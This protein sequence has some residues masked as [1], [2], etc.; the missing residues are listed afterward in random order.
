[1]HHQRLGPDNLIADYQAPR[2]TLYW[3]TALVG[4][5]KSV[6][7]KLFALGW[8][9]GARLRLALNG[10]LAHVKGSYAASQIFKLNLNEPGITH[11]RRQFFLIR[12]L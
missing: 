6:A 2:T 9:L 11:H 12:K 5:T 4:P 8:I 1:M 7:Q 10:A 3:L